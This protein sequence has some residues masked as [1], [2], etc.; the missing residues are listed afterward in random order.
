[1][2]LS[3]ANLVEF[4][5]FVISQ[6]IFRLQSTHPSN[7]TDNIVLLQVGLQQADPLQRDSFR[8]S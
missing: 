1:M 8:S 4:L 5:L 7:I 6:E 3:N 2:G